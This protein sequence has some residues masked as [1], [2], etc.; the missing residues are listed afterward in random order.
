MCLHHSYDS[1]VD[2]L[3]ITID[4]LSDPKISAIVFKLSQ[5]ITLS[6][7][8]LVFIAFEKLFVYFM[9]PIFVI[10]AACARF[11][12]K[13]LSIKRMRFL[14]YHWAKH[15]PIYRIYQ[16]HIVYIARGMQDSLHVPNVISELH[17]EKSSISFRGIVER[18]FYIFEVIGKWTLYIY[19]VLTIHKQPLG[20]F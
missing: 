10:I 18:N 11:I 3:S 1:R 16:A 8:Y 14:T 13:Q 9:Y 7:R 15:V 19:T 17:T 12:G 20:N 5:R 6:L 2:N 4:K